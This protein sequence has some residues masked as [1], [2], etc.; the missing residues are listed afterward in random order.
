VLEASNRSFPDVVGAAVYLTNMADFAAMNSI[1]A[2]HFKAPYPA[3]TT[4]A[5]AAL[6]LGASVEID[7]IA[8]AGGAR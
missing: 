2:K 4:I 1:Y 3:C 8:A 7:V 5:V 6:P